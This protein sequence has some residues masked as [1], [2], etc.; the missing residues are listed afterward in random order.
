MTTISKWLAVVTILCSANVA[1]AIDDNSV[2]EITKTELYDTIS[3][4]DM[5]WEAK[6]K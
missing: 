6:E 1:K 4:K 5:K 3:I 2:T